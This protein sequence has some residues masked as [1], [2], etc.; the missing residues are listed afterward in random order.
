MSWK[1]PFTGKSKIERRIESI[2]DRIGKEKISSFRDIWMYKAFY[3]P[4]RTDII[5]RLDNIEEDIARIVK[6]LDIE[7]KTVAERTFYRKKGK[8]IK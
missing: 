5:S 4:N 7:S 6:Y 3:G 1:L 2:E 8:K